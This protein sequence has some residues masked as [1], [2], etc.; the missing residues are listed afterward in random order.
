MS[1]AAYNA[2]RPRSGQGSGNKKKICYVKPEFHKKGFTFP[3]FETWQEYGYLT[4][5]LWTSRDHII[6]IIPGYDPETKEIFRQ[7]VNVNEYSEEAELINYISGTFMVAATVQGFGEGRNAFVTSYAP[8]S[9]EEQ[10]YGGDTMISIFSRNVFWTVQPTKGRK[11]RFGCIPIMHRW[12]AM[13]EGTLSRDRRSILVQALIYKLQGDWL[14][15][16]DDN[17]LLDEDG[18][19][20]PKIGVVAFDSP[21]TVNAVLRALVEPANPAKELDALTNNKYGGFAEL[22]GNKMY[23]NPAVSPEP[24]PTK[25]LQPS[26]HV[27]GTK[28][29]ELDMLPLTPDQVYAWWHPW[30]EIINYLTPEQQAELLAAEFGADAVNY[31]VGTDPA[32]RDF[33]MPASVA[34]AGYGR[35]AE[36]TDGVKEVRTSGTVTVPA[37]GGV[38]APG[39]NKAETTLAAAF[40]PAKSPVSKPA[41][42]TPAP[43]RGPLIPKGSGVDQSPSSPFSATLG[44]LRRATKPVQQEEPQE[45]ADGLENDNFDDYEDEQ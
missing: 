21:T 18:E 7:N 14:K 34:A 29:W 2:W 8:G 11:A 38:A 13:K 28:T 23:L 33:E 9:P 45:N 5:A 26:V 16:M 35:F 4:S 27:A 32:Y 44:Q 1:S 10:K 25:Y 36:F 39:K 37:A 22:E 3:G 19:H 31:F 15:D 41:G 42:G 6:R 12:T 24:K 20:L 17:Y 43:T 30:S 40:R